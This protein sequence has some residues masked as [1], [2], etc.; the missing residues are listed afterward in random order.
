MIAGEVN[1][2]RETVPLILNEELGLRKSC[3]KRVPRPLAELQR[4]ARLSAVFDIQIHYGDTA[5][6]LLT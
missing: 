6:S 2:N 1:M 5:A 3:A 4:D